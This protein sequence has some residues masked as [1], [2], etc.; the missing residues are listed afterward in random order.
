MVAVRVGA[1]VEGRYT[2][3]DISEAFSF[4]EVYKSCTDENDL[5]IDQAMVAQGT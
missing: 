2:L 4:R 3:V 1:S 5:G